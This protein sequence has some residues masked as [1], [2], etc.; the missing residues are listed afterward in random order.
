MNAIYTPRGSTHIAAPVMDAVQKASVRTGI[1]F[2]YLVDVARV[3]SGYN[4]TAKAPTSSARGLYQFT[5][6]TWLATLDRHGADHGLAWAANAIGRDASGRLSVADP[7]LRQQIFDLRD[8]P[9]ASS[10]MAAALTGDN[11]AYLESRIGRSAEPVDLYLAHF[12]GSGGAAKFLA[13]LEANPDQPGATMMPEAAAANRSVFY[14]A[15]GSMRSLAEIRERFRLKLEDGGTIENMKPF[16]PSGWHAQ[17]SSSSGLAGAG[18]GRPPLQMMDIQ[19]MPKKLSMGFAA[20][21]YRR[22]AS[23][24]GGAA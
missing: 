14:A 17:A 4:P 2:D 16:A 23:L 10:N 24:S 9:A 19:P 7:T 8:D 11:R 3:E 13:A 21:A 1:D 15:N 5:K 18:G 22:L 12:L 6:Q 20:D